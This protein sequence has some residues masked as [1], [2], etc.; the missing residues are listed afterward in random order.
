VKCTGLVV[1]PLTED[2]FASI[3]NGIEQGRIAYAHVRKVVWLLIST[4]A[5][6]IV[7]FFP[8]FALN[9]PLLLDAVRLRS[10]KRPSGGGLKWPPQ[11]TG[12]SVRGT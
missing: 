5:A 1:L 9:M 11:C 12:G 7:L 3:V 6:E 2:R 10:V 8:A 4:G